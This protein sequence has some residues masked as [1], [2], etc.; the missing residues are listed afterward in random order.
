MFHAG[1]R[2]KTAWLRAESRTVR[3][4]L[5]SWLCALVLL[6][7][8]LMAKTQ[9]AHVMVRGEATWRFGE[10]LAGLKAALRSLDLKR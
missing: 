3:R 8:M 4:T 6:G 7:S 5:G 1:D 10:D 9:G 2:S